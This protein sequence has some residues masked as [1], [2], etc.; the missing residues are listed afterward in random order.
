MSFM[1]YRAYNL[2]RDLVIQRNSFSI[3]QSEFVDDCVEL[4]DFAR[5]R[6]FDCVYDFAGEPNILNARHQI[7]C[8][9][10]LPISSHNPGGSRGP[11]QRTTRKAHSYQLDH[12]C[13]LNTNRSTKP[14]EYNAKMNSLQPFDHARTGRAL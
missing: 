8:E 13:L 2:C 5:T 10:F 11:A 12:R 14:Y 9:T 1:G 4:A 6:L 7:A 3:L